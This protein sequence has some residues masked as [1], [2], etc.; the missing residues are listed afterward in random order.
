MKKLLLLLPVLLLGM[1]AGIMAKTWT[2]V[3][4]KS[5]I[6]A[7]QGQEATFAFI[8]YNTIPVWSGTTM[9]RTR[10]IPW[11]VDYLITLNKQ[12]EVGNHVFEIKE[13]EN[14][15]VQKSSDKT[16]MRK[17]YNG[18]T[19]IDNLK[20]GFTFKGLGVFDNYNF[21]DNVTRL[22]IKAISI[23]AKH[24]PLAGQ[25]V[26]AV[27]GPNNQV[28]VKVEPKGKNGKIKIDPQ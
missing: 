20:G 7:T 10:E 4:D 14:G 26:D 16:A 8:P 22:Q 24:S 19:K 3:F 18:F 17:A 23:K 13:E 11:G 1:T 6:D 12:N 25:T 15:R 2:I 21:F 9:H 28:T 27:I 5:F